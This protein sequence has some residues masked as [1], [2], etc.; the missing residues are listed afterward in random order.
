M[1]GSS[2]LVLVGCPTV[3][4]IYIADAI[5]MEMGM[6]GRVVF[7]CLGLGLDTICIRKAFEGFKCG[8]VSR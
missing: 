5:Y 2:L 6:L 7:A 1:D 8:F 4:H 3:T